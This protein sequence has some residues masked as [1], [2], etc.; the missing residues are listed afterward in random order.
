MDIL[1]ILKTLKMVGV[2]ISKRLFRNENI[3]T[4]L[5]KKTDL[6]FIIERDIE[7]INDILLN[8]DIEKIDCEL[9]CNF[10]KFPNIKDFIGNIYDPNQSDPL[11][12]LDINKIYS[13]FANQVIKYF[14]LENYNARS[15]STKLFDILI[16]GC[17][18][19]LTKLIDDGEIQPHDA[20]FNYNSFREQYQKI[21]EIYKSLND[22]K[23]NP[24]YLSRKVCSAE[25][26]NSNFFLSV[27][28]DNSITTIEKY[29]NI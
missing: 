25:N 5:F 24:D 10:F 11:G 26:Y 7:Q 2:P 22:Y 27:N 3:E 19:S 23:C 17:N 29:I 15:F 8:N 14:K 12:F 18:E 21:R 16:E 28:L 6:S 13:E 4:R 1:G 20:S 9:L